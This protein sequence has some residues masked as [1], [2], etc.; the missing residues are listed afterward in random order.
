MVCVLILYLIRCRLVS[1]WNV[2][3]PSAYRQATAKFNQWYTFIDLVSHLTQSLW[4]L[5][6]EHALE[7]FSIRTYLDWLDQQILT[8]VEPIMDDEFPEG[9]LNYLQGKVSNL[10]S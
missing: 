8:D 1:T 10:M 5:E 9:F 3:G 7:R 2:I 6:L 4:T